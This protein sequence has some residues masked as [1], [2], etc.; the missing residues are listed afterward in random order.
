MSQYT[1]YDRH[2]NSLRYRGYN[3]QGKAVIATYKL[4]PELYIPTDKP[5]KYKAL[6]G[7]PVAPIKFSHFNDMKDFI[8]RYEGVSGFKYYGQDRVMWQHIQKKFPNEIDFNPSLVNVVNLD[9]EVH[10]EDGFPDPI[11]AQHPITAITIKSSTSA[12]YQVWGCGDYDIDKTPH[13]HLHIRYH[14][15]EDEYQLLE[16]FV[17]WWAG[18]GKEHYPEVLTGWNVRG[19][20]IPY[21][22]NRI[23]RLFGQQAANH[24]SPWGV[25]RE[26]TITLKTGVMKE[27]Q[28]S[29]ISQLD[30]MD[31]FKKFGYSY[32]PQ[33]SYSLNHISSV[34]LGETKMSYEEYGSLR[35]LYKENYQLYI[36]YNIKDV[37]LIERLDEK[38]DL[39]GLGFTLAY[40]AGVNFTDIFGTTAIWDS[41]IF[42][43][44]AKRDIIVPSPPDRSEREYL[45]VSFAG[46]Y[47]K[48]PQVGAHDWVVSFDLNSLYPNIIAQWNMSPET[49]VMNGE[50]V[51]RASNGVAFDN[52][53]EGVFPLLVKKYY[54]ERKDVKK[55]MI[56]WQK[57]QQKGT[58]KEIEK[59]IASLNN[60]QMAV[61]ILMNSLFG[62]IGN[63]W[64]RYFD[65]RVAE[66]ITLTGQHVIKTCEKT[67]NSEMN[68]LLSTDNVDYVIAIDTDSVYVNFKAFVEKFKPKDPVKFLDEVCN[69]HF[70]KVLEESLQKI[71]DDMN[72]FENRMVM[73]REVIADRGIWTA[74]K[75]YILNVHNSEGVQY[76]EP[77]LKIMGIE[78]IKS[79]TPEVCR[80]KFKEI[81]KIIIN[82]S[83]ADTQKY[84]SEFKQYFKSLPA[85]AVA[86][87]RGVSNITDWRDSKTIYKKG[88]PI[89]VRGALLYNKV[90]K[91]IKL[92]NKYELISNGDKIKFAYLK[93]PNHLKENVISFPMG[94]PKELKLDQ[95]I[96]YDKQFEKT[97]LDPLQFILNAVG[98]NPEEVATLDSFFA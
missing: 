80:S 4:E 87:P 28:I 69:T 73:E 86:F 30:Y 22:Y 62:A 18:Q 1:S 77:K 25:V 10:S 96:D 85:D 26:K 13:K 53:R 65:L 59:Q 32:G 81:F 42:R 98:W 97:F 35:N 14:K 34:V 33:E 12:L 3:H 57:E 47:V 43:E 76:E 44:L 31:L 66:G 48:E 29:G 41:I 68:K 27:V 6:D 23:V 52:S 74:K 51:S 78:A 16:R 37:E 93:L 84:I 55:E 56:Q 58:T 49:L 54:A 20:D 61:K 70:A 24:L 64:Y 89:H 5:T 39:I 7:T 60:K 71:H 95:Y 19:F 40:K 90:L 91:D 15:C 67:I 21:I 11:E 63:K 79:S 72:C 8:K 83:E 50:N 46:G 94:L 17:R 82:G 88:T 45:K 75:R 2:G 36:D 9:I 38:L 92:T